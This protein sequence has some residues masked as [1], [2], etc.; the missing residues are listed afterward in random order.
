[1]N[2]CCALCSNH[3]AGR[4][5]SRRDHREKTFCS[6]TCV[7]AFESRSGLTKGRVYE[8]RPGWSPFPAVPQPTAA[9]C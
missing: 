1:M 4:L 2:V 9:H 5:F 8:S 6:V 7:E 3:I